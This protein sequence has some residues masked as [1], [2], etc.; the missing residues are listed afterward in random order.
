[1]SDNVHGRLS[2]GV[3]L[4][5]RKELSKYVERNAIE[6]DNISVLKL[7]RTLLGTPS[8]Y[9]LAGIYLPPE[10]SPYY[11]DTDIYN[12]VSLLEDS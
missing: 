7:S 3:V 11:E 1:M 9:L 4:L 8:D 6:I 5:G 12:G 2:G 10:H